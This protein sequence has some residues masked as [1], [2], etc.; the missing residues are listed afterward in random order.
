MSLRRSIESVEMKHTSNKQHLRLLVY[1]LPTKYQ[2]GFLRRTALASLPSKPLLHP[3]P[4]Q[5]RILSPQRRPGLDCN[6]YH[7][8]ADISAV[9]KP[10]RGGTFIRVTFPST[11]DLPSTSQTLSRQDKDVPDQEVLIR[12]QKLHRPHQPWLLFGIFVVEK[13]LV[14][15]LPGVVDF[16]SGQRFPIFRSGM[17][18]I[19]VGLEIPK[20]QPQIS[21]RFL[22]FHS[23]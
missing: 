10:S 19:F 6:D 1:R 13:V 16:A 15:A 4:P 23:T 12:E 22:H 8:P 18:E 14:V 11:L 7:T 17:W 2:P 5:P 21:T 3:H 20:L 9:L